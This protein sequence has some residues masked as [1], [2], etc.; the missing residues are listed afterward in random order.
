M[1]KTLISLLLFFIS[2]NLFCQEQTQNFVGEVTEFQKPIS[3][4]HVYNLNR[5]NGTSTNENGIFNIPVKPNDTLII[6]HI[7]YRTQRLVVSEVYLNS[8]VPV[9][10]YLEEMTNYLDIINIKNHELT[11]IL[12]S[13]SQ[14]V[15]HSQSK[16]SINSEFQ[17]L[18]N[19]TSF[20]EIGNAFKKSIISVDPLINS[21]VRVR[22]GIPMKFKDVDERNTLK[23]K[24]N[25]PERIISSLGTGYFTNTLKVPDEKIHH[26]L[27]YCDSK[28]IID[29]YYQNEI[30]AVL[31]ILQEE[32]IEYVKIKN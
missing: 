13:D 15:A 30:M 25:F 20:D 31:T 14:S 18:V 16:D 12:A 3:G 1:A 9:N 5:L 7:K 2:L 17:N 29:L 32:S 27:T 4:V 26:F 10:I 8:S 6:S 11:G 23:N 22:V 28:N 21:T 24:R 19:Q